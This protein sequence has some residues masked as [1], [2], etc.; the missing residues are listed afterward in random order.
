[1]AVTPRSPRGLAVDHVEPSRPGVANQPTEHRHALE[2]IVGARSRAGLETRLRR[3]LETVEIVDE[4]T[5]VEVATDDAV[6]GIA[7][8]VLR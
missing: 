8:V 7:E 5:R 3:F 6:H 4:R 2:S 1:M